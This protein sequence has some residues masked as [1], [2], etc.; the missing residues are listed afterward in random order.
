MTDRQRRIA[1]LTD[2]QM[3]GLLH[4]VAAAAI[5]ERSRATLRLLLCQG[6]PDPAASDWLDRWLAMPQLRD[7]LR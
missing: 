6:Q 2:D 4:D 7:E 5:P 3:T 1:G